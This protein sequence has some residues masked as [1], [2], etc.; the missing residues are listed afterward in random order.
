MRLKSPTVAGIAFLGQVMYCSLSYAGEAKATSPTSASEPVVAPA[1]GGSPEKP[2]PWTAV[3]RAGQKED[4]ITSQAD[5]ASAELLEIQ[6]LA[7]REARGLVGLIYGGVGSDTLLFEGLSVEQSSGRSHQEKLSGLF[8]G[9]IFAAGV[10]LRY[11]INAR[12]DFQSRVALG[13]SVGLFS[14]AWQDNSLFSLS[15]DITFRVRGSGARR[16]TG[17]FGLG[18]IA[19]GQLAVVDASGNV[20]TT[21]G[22]VSGKTTSIIAVGFA[23]GILEAGRVWGAREQ[24]EL[25]VRWAFAGGNYFMNDISLVFGGMIGGRGRTAPRTAHR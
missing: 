13:L 17:Y 10:G 22:Y 23:G 24:W 16:G 12:W 18:M 1:S 8:L 4:S 5:R 15:G 3:I 6:H 25:G 11:P 21:S 14:I 9:A 19:G 2:D 20:P 7:A